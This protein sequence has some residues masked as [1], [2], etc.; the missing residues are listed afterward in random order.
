MEPKGEQPR[1]ETSGAAKRKRKRQKL[2]A[3]EKSNIAITSF[4]KPK[5]T[6]KE[7]DMLEPEMQEPELDSAGMFQFIIINS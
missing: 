3:L 1:S 7:S 6:V 5:Q 2:E 4:F